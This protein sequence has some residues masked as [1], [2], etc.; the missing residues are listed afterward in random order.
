MKRWLVIP[1]LFS[2]T[3]CLF[4]EEKVNEAKKFINEAEERLEKK[5]IEAERINWIYQTYITYDTSLIASNV[6]EELSNLTMALIKDST[7][8]TNV[9][10]DPVTDR[11]F[12]L[13]QVSVNLATPSDSSKSSRLAK[14]ATEMESIYSTGKACVD[15]KCYSLD[16][17]IKILADSKDYKLALKL[18]KGWR[19]AVGP[20]IKPL[21]SEYVSLSNQG[22]REIG[23][24]DVGELW[25]SRFDMPS[26]RF[27]EVVDALWQEVKP[28][29][30]SLHCY[31]RGRLSDYYGDDLV[32]KSGYIPAHILGNM[33]AQD[34]SNIYQIIAPPEFR[35]KMVSIKESLNKKGVDEKGMVK[36]AENFFVSLGFEPLPDSFWERSMFKRP[37]DREVVCH[38]SAWNI[39][40][41]DDLRIKMC[42]SITDED[43]KVI[44]HELGHNFYQ[45]AY[46][47]QPPLFRAGAHTGFHEA[48]GDT[49]VLS[50]TPSYLK[51]IGLIEDIPEGWDLPFLLQLALEKVVFLPFGYLIDKWRWEV[52]S[53]KISEEKFNERWWELRKELQG[54]A[55][56]VE[57]TEKDFDPG[58]KYHIPANVPYIRYFLAHILQFQ[59]HK[60]LCD[61]AGFKGP[62]HECSIYKSRKAGEKFIEM[63]QKGASAPWMDTL[64]VLTGAREMSAK[65]L[66]IYFS[67][68]KKWLDSENKKYGYKCGW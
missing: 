36:Y 47:D 57:R 63:M 45:R 66:L 4:S 1:L 67:P 14:V 65:P 24:A 39:D 15:G 27:L 68:L 52:F 59:F 3:F 28:L 18:W 48:I 58:A 6:N 31:V 60:A 32:P 21:Y 9:I 62:L 44:H 19:D 11:K 55:P 30:E 5:W 13:L 38:A 51:E 26:E 8:F 54:I 41:K 17:A 56:P 43:F 20:K 2:S 50:I 46:K 49:I 29:Y 7:K 10:K 23:F 42:I 34:W 12:K 37:R 22:A 40:M 53:G 33:W 16:E 61:L 64:A 35:R 25:R